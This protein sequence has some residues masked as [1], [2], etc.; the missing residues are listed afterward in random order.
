MA[1]GMILILRDRCSSGSGSRANERPR[2]EKE[3]YS[4]SSVVQ[5][6]R[7]TSKD[8][9]VTVR[10]AAESSGQVER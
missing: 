10:N 8:G 3:A 6:Q 1:L 9:G 4:Q 5:C 2:R 7:I